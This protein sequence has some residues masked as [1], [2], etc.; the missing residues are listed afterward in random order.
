MKPIACMLFH[1]NSLGEF[2]GITLC[3]TPDD[4]LLTSSLG[5][6]IQIPPFLIFRSFYNVLIYYP[7]QCMGEGEYFN[8]FHHLGQT[9]MMRD[10]YKYYQKTL[11]VMAYKQGLSTSHFE[12]KHPYHFF[13]TGW[14]AQ[15]FIKSVSIEMNGIFWRTMRRSR[16]TWP[17]FN[18]IN[19]NQAMLETIGQPTMITSAVI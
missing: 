12:G 4:P 10:V 19:K 3:V 9:E 15:I 5:S 17:V 14:L 7:L 16:G 2:H 11:K 18:L 13:P 8:L 6:P 1:L